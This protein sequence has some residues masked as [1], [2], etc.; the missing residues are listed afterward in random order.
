[1]LFFVMS[2]ALLAADPTTASTQLP[3]FDSLWNYD[4]PA[5]TEDKLRDVIPDAL[6]LADRSYYLQLL[7]Q[8]ARAQ[9]MQNHFADAQVT[10]D[11]VQQEMTPDMKL[12]QVRYLLERGR[13]FN[14]SDQPAKAIPLFE[15]AYALAPQEKL[16]FFTIDAAH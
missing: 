15:Q 9:G 14:S 1:M 16:D 3:D 8:I 2:I 7:T 5:A 6:S 11:Q 12:V 13:V 4:D 10:L